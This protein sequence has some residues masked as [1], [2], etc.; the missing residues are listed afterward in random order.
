MRDEVFDTTVR[1]LAEMSFAGRIS[2]HLYNEPLLRRDLARLVST[3]DGLLPDALQVLNTNG[4]LLDD[5]RYV[6]LRRAGVDYF[7]VT[8]HE[9]GPYP[10]RPFSGTTRRRPLCESSCGPVTGRRRPC[11]WPARTCT[12]PN[13]VGPRWSTSPALSSRLDHDGV[14]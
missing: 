12:T 14:K 8:R 1:Q 9:P 3:V 11:A 13:P 5:A 7:Y 10:D 6:E 2:Y 4:D